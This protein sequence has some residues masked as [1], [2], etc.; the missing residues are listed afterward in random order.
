MAEDR[1]MLETLLD[2][3]FIGEERLSVAELRRRAVAEGMPPDVLQS[4]GTL[5]EGE[6]AQDEV[7]DALHTHAVITPPAP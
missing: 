4:V 1:E 5:P 6:Y 3:L 2:T 7:L